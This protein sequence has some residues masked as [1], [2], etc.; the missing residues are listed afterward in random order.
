MQEV[1]E[2]NFRTRFAPSPTGYLHIGGARTALFNLLFAR[3]NKGKFILRIEDTDVARSTEESIKAILDGMEWLGLHWDEGPF[4]QSKRFD[5][6]REHAY[7][8]LEAGE[9]Y[10]CYCTPE[11]LEARREAAMKEGRPPKYDGRCKNIHEKLDKPFALRFKVPPGTT[12]VRDVIK[13][14]ISFDNSTIEDLVILR[15]DTTPTY[16]FC[17]VVDDATM[18]ITHVIRG[19]DHL[20]NT[21]KQILLYKALGHELPVFAHL[22]MILGSDKTRLSK[23]HGATSVMAYKEMGYLPQALVNYLARLG[24]SHGD[25]EIFSMNDL[26]EKFTLES[27]GASSGVFNPEKLLW[28]NQHYIKSTPDDELAGLVAPFFEALGLNVSGDER[29]PKIA[30]TLK[31]RSRTLKDMAESGAFYFKDKAEYDPKAAEKFLTPDN[32]ELFALVIE[33]L[34]P[35]ETFAH[36]PLEE[37]FNAILAEKDLKLGKIAQPVRVALTGGTVSPGIFEMME[38]FGKGTVITRLKD[39]LAHMKS[40][41]RK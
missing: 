20:N 2:L 7:R 1:S 27:V 29:L 15:S 13:G 37:A 24:W 39:A 11:E 10:R 36:K 17:V 38:A 6:Y 28:L 31:E 34:E 33:R 19:D 12:V 14:A 16:N 23:R 3:H 32:A 8:L 26:I 9:A 40:A 35:L 4:F 30:G 21:P 5:L 41:A 18:D 25:E 22:P